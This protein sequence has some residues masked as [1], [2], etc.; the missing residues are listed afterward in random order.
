[1]QVFFSVHYLFVFSSPKGA[2][3]V[4]MLIVDFFLCLYTLSVCRQRTCFLMQTW[5]SRLQILASVMSSLWGTN[6]THSVA[7]RPTLPQSSSRARST[8]ALRWTSGAW[9]L[10][11]IHWSVARCPSMDRTSRWGRSRVCVCVC[12]LLY[13]YNPNR[14]L[15]VVVVKW[16]NTKKR[17]ITNLGTLF[18]AGLRVVWC[19]EHFKPIFKLLFLTI[20]CLT[21]HSQH[22]SVHTWLIL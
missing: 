16:V 17:I 18:S 6:W 4:F 22:Q 19:T 8:T 2:L 20:I 15:R 7:L 10:S 11:F 1:M 9:G 14:F 5:T 3:A 13:V 21:N 12:V